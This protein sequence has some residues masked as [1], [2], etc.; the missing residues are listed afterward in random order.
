MYKYVFKDYHNRF[1]EL[2]QNEKRRIATCTNIPLI[3][4]HIGSTAIPGLGGKGIIDIAIAVDKADLETVAKQ[5]QSIGYAFRPTFSTPDRY[6]FINFLADPID[7]SRRYHIHLTYPENVEWKDFLGFRDYLINHPK[8]LQEYAKIK[9]KAVLKADQ[10][11][12]KYR[13][14]KEPIFKKIRNL[15]NSTNEN[16]L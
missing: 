11:G 10:D 15:I 7:K 1:P 2:F 12:E 14:L 9:R 4:E 13:K 8:A 6:Y 16:Q 3:I 5:L